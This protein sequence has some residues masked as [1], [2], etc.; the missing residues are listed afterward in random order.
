VQTNL[1]APGMRE[2][3]IVAAVAFLIAI[4]LASLIVH[5]IVP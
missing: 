5:F 4:T 3:V 1:K 2:T